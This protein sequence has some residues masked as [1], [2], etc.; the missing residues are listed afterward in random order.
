M[1]K[2]TLIVLGLALAFLAL[3]SCSSSPEKA[4]LS[5]YFNAVT[6][7]DNPTMASIALEPAQ[8]DVASWSIT[9]VT[10]E[11]IEPATLP[12]LAKKETEAKDALEKHIAPT[13]EAKDLLDAAQEDLDLA[14]TAGAKAAAKKKVDELQAKYDEEY[15]A[16]K[17]LQ[18]Q[19]N[20]A[21]A[22]AATEEQITAFSLGIRDLANIRDL[23]GNV[24]S[25]EVD[26]KVTTKDG[27]T[28][29]YRLYMR[30]YDLRDEALN[31]HHLGQWKIIKF[32]P[33]S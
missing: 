5:R 19:Y 30:M 2:K 22:A 7:N 1:R 29:D 25:K 32:E 26:I 33:L 27:A 24:H 9:S 13:M 11:K 28:K 14:R 3:Q 12:E 4:L 15:N 23:I 8:M 10:P 17:E 31:L 16:H 18:K 21:K 20:D 6:L